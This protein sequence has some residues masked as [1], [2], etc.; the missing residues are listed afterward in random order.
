MT[1][2][3][4]VVAMVFL[5]TLVVCVLRLVRR[6]LSWPV[7]LLGLGVLVLVFVVARLLVGGSV[8]IGI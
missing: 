7:A 1:L 4:V 2:G 5:V 3:P 8:S 6:R